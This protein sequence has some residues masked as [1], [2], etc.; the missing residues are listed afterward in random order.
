MGWQVFLEKLWQDFQC[1]DDLYAFFKFLPHEVF[2]PTEEEHMQTHLDP[3][4]RTRPHVS[5]LARITRTSPLGVFVRRACLEFARLQ[6]DD[7]IKLW[8][9]F[10]QYRA[11][12]E[13]AWRIKKPKTEP[14]RQSGSP[15][16]HVPTHQDH[17]LYQKAYG[18][19]Q[20]QT[21]SEGIASI[22]DIERLLE[23]QLEQLQ[24]YGNRVPEEMKGQF[25]AMVSPS[26]SVPSLSH[27]VR[28]FDAWRAGDYTSSFDNLHRYFDYTMSTKDKTYYQYALLHM[29]V[30]QAD[31]GCFSE[32]HAAMQ[33]T[34]ATAR[35]N[36]DM[37]CLNFSLS[38]LHHLSKAY[39]GQMR[40]A[41]YAGITGSEREGL[42]FLEAKAKESKSW[43][44]HSSTLLSLA[45]L[46]LSNGESVARALE[47]LYQSSHLNLHH[48]LTTV[49][50][51]QMLML[52]SVLSRLGL[53]ESAEQQVLALKL[54]HESSS[55]VEEILRATCRLAYMAAQA[56][57]HDKA[58]D[59]LDE[60]NPEV[61][62]TLKFHQY[63]TVYSGMLKLKRQLQKNNLVASTHLLSE[64]KAA[65]LLDPELNF[66]LVMLELNC[67]LR[68]AKVSEAFTL[69]DDFGSRLKD[70][71]ADVY[72]RIRLLSCKAR[73]FNAAGQP[74]LGFSVALRAANASFKA[75]I[76]P[77]AWEAV[78]QLCNILIHESQFEAAV[79]LLDAIT[80]QAME[81]GDATL[82]ADLF[83]IQGDAHVGMAKRTKSGSREQGRHLG[84]ASR[85]LERAKEW[86][87]RAEDLCGQLRMLAMKAVIC[88]LRGDYDAA[89]EQA[90]QYVHVHDTA[91]ENM[92]EES[93]PNPE[94]RSLKPSKQ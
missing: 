42:E 83:A 84:E 72:Q 38:W 52:S 30:L 40:A 94:F 89:D 5:P 86:Y 6:F 65:S 25:R 12:S 50:G 53:A 85:L 47:Y 68:Q 76:L 45:K 49:T 51:A 23:Y 31:F 37:N 44:L 20:N 43:S 64:L 8:E 36:Q 67:L 61:H 58:T 78:G 19:L 33:E 54:C 3:E 56:G 14:A 92:R 16:P 82:C 41:G 87:E 46:T 11:P 69:I 73:I 77:A 10:V 90:A 91:M 27:F 13:A 70:E 48:N 71:G 9:D 55:P 79:E 17:P 29:A 93:G 32:A 35:E 1:L 21:V 80:P 60:V 22:E 24:K 63:L 28:F 4:F 66:E 26:V 15:V 62:R 39:P 59:L 34:I 88:R 57:Y 81:G 18:H 75:R 74:Q 2:Q 7:T